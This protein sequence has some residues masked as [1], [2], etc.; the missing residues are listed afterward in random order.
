VEGDEGPEPE[1]LRTCLRCRAYRQMVHHPE[2]LMFPQ[3]RVGAKGEGKFK[4]ISWDVPGPLPTREAS[5]LYRGL[6]GSG[7]GCRTDRGVGGTVWN[8][9]GDRGIQGFHPYPAGGRL[10]A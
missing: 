5:Q 4:R 8:H 2:R 10:Q 6:P 9:S 7:L 1:Q 3:K